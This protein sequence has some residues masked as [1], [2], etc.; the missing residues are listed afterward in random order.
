MRDAVEIL[1]SDAIVCSRRITGSARG[2]TAASDT[3]SLH[4]FTKRVPDSPNYVQVSE[5]DAFILR[6]RLDERSANPSR[7]SADRRRA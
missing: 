6:G 1:T 4:F 2:S 3:W 7:I 5:I